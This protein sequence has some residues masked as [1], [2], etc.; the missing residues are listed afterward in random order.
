MTIREEYFILP[1]FSSNSSRILTHLLPLLREIELTCIAL[2]LSSS[3]SAFVANQKRS[4]E[5][6]SKISSSPS[7]YRGMRIYKRFYTSAMIAPILFPVV[8]VYRVYFLLGSDPR[9]SITTPAVWLDLT[10]ICEDFCQR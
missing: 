6:H 4:N 9:I 1:S 8:I 3:P 5:I 7:Q 10:I 2:P